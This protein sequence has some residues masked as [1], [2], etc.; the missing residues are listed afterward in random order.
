MAGCSLQASSS[1]GHLYGVL[2][3]VGGLTLG[4][5]GRQPHAPPRDGG[6]D[7]RDAAFFVDGSLRC[8]DPTGDED[9]DGIANGEEGCLQ[10]RNSD[11]DGV[12]DWQD[13][14][15][16]GDGINDSI[17]KGVKGSCLGPT[18]E[19]WPCDSDG[20]GLPDYLDVDSDDDGVLDKDE[21]ENG[22]GLIGCCLRRCG[23]PEGAQRWQGWGGCVLNAEGC[24]AGQKCV[25]GLCTPP[26]AFLCSDGETD[27]R[28]ADSF[29]DGIPDGERGT[30][31]CRDQSAS[32]PH[33]R[34]QVQKRQSSD[35]FTDPASGDWKL[36]LELDA[37]YSALS[38]PGAVEKVAAATIDHR[39]P[40]QLVAGFIVSLPDTQADIEKELKA[41]LAKISAQ[42]PGG[43]GTVGVRASGTRGK[44]HDKFDAVQG[45]MLDISLAG[46][47]DPSTARN[48]LIATLLGRPLTEFGP[49]PAA[50]AGV[51]GKALVLRLH[52]L[53]RFAF[54]RDRS[55]TLILDAAGYPKEDTTRPYERRILVMGAV[56]LRAHYEDKSRKTGIL[57]DDLSNGTLLADTCA[58]I[59]DECD[60]GTISAHALDIIWVIDESASL[61][62]R[63]RAVSYG[64]EF[65]RRLQRSDIDF[66]M[67]VTNVVRPNAAGPAGDSRVGKLCSRASTDPQDDGGVDRFLLPS[68]RTLFEACLKNPPGYPNGPPHGLEN[69]L[70]ALQKHLPRSGAPDKI[71]PGASIAL[72]AVTDRAAGE[73]AGV[74]DRTQASTCTLD[75]TTQ[76]TVDALVKPYRFLLWDPSSY[77]SPVFRVIG[78]VCGNSCGAAPAHGYRELAQ[79]FSRTVSDI[80]EQDPSGTVDNIVYQAIEYSY[81]VWLDH[82]PI[83]PSLTVTVDGVEIPR[84]R[85]RGFDYRRSSW[86]RLRFTGVPFKRHSQI[87]ISYKRWAPPPT[88]CG[89]W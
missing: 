15:S 79:Y 50:Y 46:S 89:A 65:F 14:D 60:V 57:V 41:L 78:G 76:A 42:P 66:R 6:A 44:S 2:L 13:F 63:Q 25:S 37:K 35:P 71:R 38:I 68:E 75:A 8:T 34:K 61:A 11:D 70:Q 9:G 59:A 69:A 5:S 31:I 40:P 7:L 48:Q 22:D 51:Q 86:N 52:T 74:L 20:D 87:V 17:E 49:L 55:N 23:A 12:P 84:S 64:R 73:L 19:R 28:R 85:Q 77:D 88:D 4:C 27:P 26:T 45:T 10:G 53:R 32:N 36:A 80:C 81:Q 18:P 43:A 62:H 58:S 21:D 30:F 83:A 47:T 56:A 16:D 3:V 54:E 1:L 33:G 67:G 24:G 39:D 29:G 82:L 72:I